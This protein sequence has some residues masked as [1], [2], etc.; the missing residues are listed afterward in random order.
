MSPSCCNDGAAAG[1]IPLL[2]QLAAKAADACPWLLVGL[3]SS[4]ALQSANLPVERL[5]YWLSGSKGGAAPS[6][7]VFALRCSLASLLGLA[8]PLCSCGAFPVAL[9][10]AAQ[11]VSPAAVVSFLTSAQSA[12]IDSAAITVGMLGWKMAFFRLVG[13]F[14]LSVSAG[15]AVGRTGSSQACSSSLGELKNGCKKHTDNV[16]D[17]GCKP[18]AK[19]QKKK[20]HNEKKMVD[21]SRFSLNVTALVRS[22]YSLLDEIWPVLLL[23]IFVSVLVERRFGASDLAAANGSSNSM[24]TANEAWEPKPDWWD[25][26]EDGEYPE[27]PEDSQMVNESSFSFLARVVVLV[28]ALPFQL[29]EHGVVSFASALQKAGASYGTAH[30]F[31]L[32]APATN[33]STIGAVVKCTGDIWAAMRSCVAI[34]VSALVLSYVVESFVFPRNSGAAFLGEAIESFVLPQWWSESSVWICGLMAA[35]SLY[36]RARAMFSFEA[37]RKVRDGFLLDGKE[38]Q[39]KAKCK[40]TTSTRGRRR[41]R[42]ATPAR[43]QVTTH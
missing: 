34:S 30:V 1:S 10:L 39:T 13:A 38:T 25:D 24:A 3:L 27:P 33:L 40:K 11:G 21:K 15:L 43:E 29:C 14:I 37:E 9:S 6:H 7:W 35:K 8:T 36:D 32:V 2:E 17:S 42:A 12:G 28:G 23:G 41:K 19:E 4:V 26:E 16:C 18:K 20:I 5:R 22:T 31:L